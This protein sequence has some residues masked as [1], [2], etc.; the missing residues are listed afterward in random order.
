MI[1]YSM[2]T[3]DK[4]IAVWYNDDIET[5]TTN[6]RKENMN[7]EHL[8][9]TSIH[10]YKTLKE[11]TRDLNRLNKLIKQ[12]NAIQIL[13]INYENLTIKTSN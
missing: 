2:V 12:G 8:K 4:D 13:I 10:Q 7:M 5:N 11:M 1:A 3:I 6:K 9:I